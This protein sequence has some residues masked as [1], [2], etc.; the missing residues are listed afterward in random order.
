MFDSRF[1]DVRRHVNLGFTIVELLAVC[2]VITL[3]MAVL[4]PAIQQARESARRILCSNNLRQLS[5]ALHHYE[6]T[7]E[8]LPP[9]SQVADFRV[10]PY[11]SKSF[12][13]TVAVL[14]HVEHSALFMQFDFLRDCQI[15][16]RPQTRQRISTFIC[17]SD[18]VG[19]GPVA[20]TPPHGEHSIWGK[21][22]EGGW[23][24]S[25]YFGVSG[26]SGGLRAHEPNACSDYDRTIV[27]GVMNAGLFFGNSSVR[28]TDVTDGLSNTFMLTERGGVGS[29]GKWGGAGALFECPFGLYDVTMPG[30]MSQVR[31]GLRRP[32][33]ADS[34][35]QHLWS[36]HPGGCNY[37]LADGS[38]RFVSYSMQH[39]LQS[40]LSTRAHA[41]VGSDW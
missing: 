28:L 5:L 40:A 36:Y 38:V 15:H 25:N 1:Q 23:G 11:Y 7:C 26:I 41:E 17:T 18:P 19:G 20:W 27:N 10:A 37:S 34:D 13:W 29:W 9:G 35:R 12:G 16:N 3:L 33:H 2:A 31:G 8:V 32:V 39:S 6:A 24:V 30:V 21:Y 14:P 22:Y 4:L